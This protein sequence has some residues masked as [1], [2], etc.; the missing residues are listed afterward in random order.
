MLTFS[1]NSAADL[2]LIAKDDH[3][4]TQRFHRFCEGRERVFDGL[5]DFSHGSF[6]LAE[7]G[8]VRLYL[9]V[10]CTAI[11]DKSFLLN[12]S[13]NISLVNG[14]LFVKPS[15]GVA[16]VVDVRVGAVRFIEIF[17]CNLRPLL[18]PNYKLLVA[19]STCGDRILPTESRAFRI[20]VDTFMAVFFRF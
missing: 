12:G 6:K 19:V 1:S 10:D 20:F 7:K 2:K 5:R 13:G 18:A 8:V 14:R 9:T 16:P 3:L 11:G 4:F 15:V 17:V